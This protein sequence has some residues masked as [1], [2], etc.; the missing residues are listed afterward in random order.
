M[1]LTLKTMILPERSAPQ[2]VDIMRHVESFTPAQRKILFSNLQAIELTKGCSSGCGD[3]MLKVPKGVTQY[4]SYSSFS[5]FVEKYHAELPNNIAFHYGS[6]TLD[7]QDRE[8]TIADVY[9]LYKKYKP[10]S[11]IYFSTSFPPGKERTLAMTIAEMVNNIT[12]TDRIGRDV[13]HISLRQHGKNKRIHEYE[14]I[15]LRLNKVKELVY[16]LVDGPNKRHIDMFFAA[17]INVCISDVDTDREQLGRTYSRFLVYRDALDMPISPANVDGVVLG[18]DGMRGVMFDD[19]DPYHST[20]ESNWPI[21]STQFRVPMKYVYNHSLLDNVLSH[22]SKTNEMYDQVMIQDSELLTDES[23]HQN[24]FSVSRTVRALRQILV[25]FATYGA[26]WKSCTYAQ[27][28]HALYQEICAEYQVKKNNL[29]H[30]YATQQL[31]ER[32]KYY[33]TTVSKFIG[34]YDQLIKSIDTQIQKGG[35]KHNIIIDAFV[36]ASKMRSHDIAGYNILEPA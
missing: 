15:K 17:G 12:D 22:Y 20:G 25:T 26:Y 24:V 8:H 1:E 7:Y 13:I 14:Q 32:D 3:C 9:A 30:Y 18:P 35:L 29:I 19:I 11:S 16:S 31:T 28:M 27:G 36:N 21:T 4:I 33:Q 5:S 2:A 6:D 10:S 34:L 23:N